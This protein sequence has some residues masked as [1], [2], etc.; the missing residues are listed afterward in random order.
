MELESSSSSRIKLL[1][2]PVDIL[3]D[4]LLEN[5]IIQLL[6]NNKPNQIVFLSFKDFIKGRSKKEFLSMLENAALVLPSSTIITKGIYF[7]Y[8]KKST[9]FIQYDFVLKILSILEKY[10]K[11]IYI[12]GSNKKNISISEKNLK[13]SYPGLHLVGRSSSYYQKNKEND[14]ILA[15]KKSSPSLVLAGSGLKGKNEWIHQYK[16]KF[17]P[18]IS[19]WSPDC[20]EIFSGKKK[21][22]SKKASVRFFVNLKSS[23]IKPWRILYFFPLIHYYLS[24]LIYRIF[25]LS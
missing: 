7:L 9:T 3:D 2:V 11:S 17:N 5:K 18:G 24:L 10:Q 4:K 6:E 20:F 14:I 12:I 13:D 16:N 22:P 15:I 23:F 25:K 19:L 8:R 1:K 21:R